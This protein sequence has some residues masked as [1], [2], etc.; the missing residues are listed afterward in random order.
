LGFKVKDVVVLAGMWVTV[1]QLEFDGADKPYAHYG[2]EVGKAVGAKYTIV[3]GPDIDPYNAE[4]VMWA[5]GMR[6]GKSSWREPE[7]PPGALQPPV[8]DRIFNDVT[9]NMG[10]LVIDATI[11][12]PERFDSFPPRSDPPEWEKVAIARMKRKIAGE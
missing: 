5:V 10:S 12:V 3:V 6:A 9:I 4:E 8:W 1:I 11:P 2:D 7:Y